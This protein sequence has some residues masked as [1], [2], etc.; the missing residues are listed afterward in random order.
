M[1]E[2]TGLSYGPILQNISLTIPEKGVTGLVGPNG[3]GKTTLLRCMFGA[4]KPSAGTVMVDGTPLQKMRPRQ[5]SQLMAVLS[6]EAIEPPAMTVAELVGLA[7]TRRS[8]AAIAASLEKVGLKDRATTLLPEL[9]GGERQRAM[10]ARALAQDA[11]YLLLD[12]PTNH[13]DIYYQLELFELLRKRKDATAVVVHDLNL[14]LQ[15]CA[16]V[17]LLN[18]GKLVAS[19]PPDQV[20]VPAVLE[21][22]YQVRVQRSS[23][24]LHFERKPE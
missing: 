8:E 11:P 21:P 16:H 13:L 3:S 23:H 24:H 4:L 6:Q 14:A 5:I 18:H 9:S 1:I 22:I 20:L 10:I 7:R 19:G 17:H 12:E 15:Y 2:V